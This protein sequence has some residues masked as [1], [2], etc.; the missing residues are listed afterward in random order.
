MAWARIS[1]K[2]A[3]SPARDHPRYLSADPDRL[4]TASAAAAAV[5][6]RTMA[7]TGPFAPN[8]GGLITAR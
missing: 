5:A 2:S 3:P 6:I 4:T 1:D 7:Q 8:I